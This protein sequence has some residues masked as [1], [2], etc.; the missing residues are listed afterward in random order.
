[1][2][3]ALPH[4]LSLAV[5]RAFRANQ[6]VA[7]T[8]EP[9]RPQR[10]PYTGRGARTDGLV[11]DRTRAHPTSYFPSILPHP[12]LKSKRFKRTGW[13]G[14]PLLRASF[15]P[16]RPRRAKTRPFPKRAPPA[17]MK[18]QNESCVRGARAR[19]AARLPMFTATRPLIPPASS[20]ATHSPFP[21]SPSPPTPSSPAPRKSRT[22]PACRP[23]TARPAPDSSR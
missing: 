1:M 21:D 18:I 23:D 16:A 3:I 13:P 15:S 17:S 20:S 9:G 22:P 19:G 5:R 2:A 7:P 6:R 10:G 4:L 11:G 8:R 14:C 12:R